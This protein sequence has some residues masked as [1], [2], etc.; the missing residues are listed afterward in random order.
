LGSTVTIALPPVRLQLGAD[1]PA[2]REHAHA[3]HG[4][5]DAK[6]ICGSVRRRQIAVEQSPFG[7]EPAS[8]EAQLGSGRLPSQISDIENSWSR[9]APGNL[10]LQHEKSE[11]PR[12]ARD[13]LPLVGQHLR[14]SDLGGILDLFRYFIALCGRWVSSI[15]ARC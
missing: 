14:F 11:I 10:D 15:P 1:G 7:F 4:L 8:A 9:D 12:Q 3:S 13:R 6:I 5:F 2:F